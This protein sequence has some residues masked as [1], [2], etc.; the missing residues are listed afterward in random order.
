MRLLFD[1]LVGAGEDR[2]WHSQ[3]ERLGGLEIDNQLECRRALDRQ[4]GGL[5]ALEDPPDVNA[6]PAIDSPEA[7]PIADQATSCSE[8]APPIDHRN[9]I[10]QCQRGKLLVTAQEERI[11]AD[12]EGASLQLD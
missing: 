8:L 4:I 10:A 6:D 7:S 12:D 9:G 1:D 2:G 11:D 5:G 3:T